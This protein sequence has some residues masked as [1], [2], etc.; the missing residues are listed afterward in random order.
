MQL[1]LKL[2]AFCDINRIFD[3]LLYTF[4][5]VKDR[6]SMY[7]KDPLFPIHI[8]CM[9]QGYRFQILF[10]LPDCAWVVFTIAWVV[11]LMSKRI[12]GTPVGKRTKICGCICQLD[13]ITFSINYIKWMGQ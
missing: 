5:F 13:Y 6:V 11:L 3:Y 9:V 10:Y 8:M 2:S 1:F 7:L 4:L 12:A